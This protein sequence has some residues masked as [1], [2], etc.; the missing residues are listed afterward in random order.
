MIV[1]NKKGQKKY[2]F[3]ALYSNH[4]YLLWFTC[5]FSPFFVFISLIY[6]L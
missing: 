1:L 2:L 4:F 5:C 6:T 3:L